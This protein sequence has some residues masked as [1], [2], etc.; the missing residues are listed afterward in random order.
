[1]ITHAARRTIVWIIAALM[2]VGVGLVPGHTW[3][4]K[5]WSGVSQNP[6]RLIATD[7]SEEEVDWS[8]GL[9]FKGILI[10]Q[11]NAEEQK[12]TDWTLG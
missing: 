1:M 4:G 11:D 6:D 2:V 12:E 5:T 8:L 9:R 10:A 3:A 7:N